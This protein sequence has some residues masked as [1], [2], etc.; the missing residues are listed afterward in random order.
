VQSSGAEG[1]GDGFSE[2]DQELYTGCG[3]A[4]NPGGF[5][6]FSRFVVFIWNSDVKG[7]GSGETALIEL[8]LISR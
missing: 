5:L 7:F 4:D 8:T 2:A 6:R 3:V 1:C